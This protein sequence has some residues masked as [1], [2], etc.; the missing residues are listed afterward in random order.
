[1][2]TKLRHFVPWFKRSEWRDIKALCA[3]R[4]LPQRYD[5]WLA[6]V[7]L[8]LKAQGLTERD[9][10]KVVLTPDD[11][12]EWKAAHARNISSRVRAGL[13]VKLGLERSAR[14]GGSPSTKHRPQ[15]VG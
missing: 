4:D 9:I 12:R 15:A 5:Q 13:A 1:M 3:P 11:L 7:R 14:A 6:A 8:G 10:Q 2:S